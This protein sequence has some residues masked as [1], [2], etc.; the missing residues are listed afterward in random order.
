MAGDVKHR[1]EELPG[2]IDPGTF[3]VILG[4]YH[5]IAKEM[6]IS[7]ER[8]AWTSSLNLA[9][10]FSCTISDSDFNLIAVP[11]ETL[12]V[13]SMSMQRAVKNL[14]A[15]LEESGREIYD[16]DVLMGNLAYLGNTH[17]GEP[18][19]VSPVF[20]DG[21]PLFWAAARGHLA[22]MGMPTYLPSYPY[23]KDVYSEGL[24]VPPVKL[25]ERGE[26]STDVLEIYL[27]N[28]RARPSSYGDL[29]AHVAATW[30]G[31]ERLLEFVETYGPE[32]V[33]LYT[34]E[35]LDYTD[36]MVGSAISE[37]KPGTYYGEDWLDTDNYGT[38]NIPIRARLT[39]TGDKWIVDLTDNEPQMIGP[40]NSTLEGCTEAAV[41]GSL[42]FCVDPRI[43][44]NEGFHR[45]IE[46]ICPEGTVVSAQYPFST[47]LSTVG[48]GETVYRCLLRAAAAASPEMVA[49][50]STLIQFSN[51]IGVDYREGR[52]KLW[53]YSNFNE[54]GGGGGAFGT[55]GNPCMME[56][57]V[58]GGMKF[59]S[60]EMEEW[61]YPVLVEQC[62]IYTDSQ[63]AGRWRGAPGVITRVRGYEAS[64]MEMWTYSWGHNNLSHGTVGGKPGVGGTVFKYDPDNPASR[65]FYSGAGRVTLPVGWEYV[66]IASGGGGYG[67]PL[68]RDPRSVWADVRDDIVSAASAGEDYGVVVRAN[69]GGA[70]PDRTTDLRAKL[71]RERG[72]PPLVSPTEPGL[73]TLREQLMTDA[74]EFVDLDR[75]PEEDSSADLIP[76]QITSGEG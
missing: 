19:L 23:A 67:D 53:S 30:R 45:H 48:G 51:Y 72:E 68:D 71:R 40:M 29:M 8:S 59:I 75:S 47:N 31:K 12:P 55:D 25:Y 41:A 58:A 22:D 5:N 6:V 17:I 43:P 32:T 39:I 10:D 26:L 36:R 20:Y 37:M 24:K 56:M 21:R 28:L 1:S 69:S 7:L 49:A 54:C 11:D 14:V 63:G 64:P 3:S 61:L 9:R 15:F 65:V 34:R 74:D 27:S 44:K 57:G 2:A 33:D 38:K 18:L 76:W 46:I 70:D 13:Q 62:E 4:T 42:A 35:L 50:G 52:K 66:V 60:I 73:S 16:G